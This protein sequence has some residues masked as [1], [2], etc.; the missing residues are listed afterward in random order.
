VGYTKQTWVN[1]DPSKPLDASRL[2]H[3]EDGLF[4][5]AATAD[6][7]A[8][9]AL[10]AATTADAAQVA[11]ALDD[12]TAALVVDTGTATG[13]ALATTIADGADSRIAAQAVLS[14]R[15]TDIANSWWSEP[16][17]YYDSIRQRIYF[18]G[19]SRGAGTLVGTAMM[20]VAYFD[21]RTGLVVK[22]PVRVGVPDDHNTPVMLITADQPPL[23]FTTN[24]EGDSVVKMHKGPAVHDFSSFTTTDIAFASPCSY[25]HAHRQPGTQNIVVITRQPDG[26]YLRRSTDWGATWGTA[27]RFH[28]K[29]YCTFR[30]VGDEL[31]YVTTVHPVDGVNIDVRY[32]KVNLT[33]G[34]ITNAAGTAIDNLWT[35]TTPLPAANMTL[36]KQYTDPNSG[37]VCGVGPDGSVIICEINKTT[38]ELGGTYRVFPVSTSGSWSSQTLVASGVPVGYYQKGYIGGAVFGATSDEVFLTRESSGTWTLEKWTRSAGVWSL[39]DTLRTVSGGKKLGRPQVPFLGEATDHVLVLEYAQYATDAYYDYYADELLLSRTLDA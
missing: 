23:I 33:T 20:Y 10:A 32:F 25:Q 27:V 28:G 2:T 36:V 34:A 7:A 9:S 26:W 38:P 17:T 18:S 12:D 16:R 30:R 11:A 39:A 15:A 29:Q 24:H 31:H 5:A 35:M 13:A 19:C 3:V 8:A 37:R 14:H 22:H 1:N 6:S 4:L 21:L